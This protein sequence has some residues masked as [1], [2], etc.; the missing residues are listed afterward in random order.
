MIKE[1]KIKPIIK[2]AGGKTSEL[3]LIHQYLPK[4]FNNYYEPFIGG[5]AVWLSLESSNTNKMF[6][7]D[8]SIDLI[9]LYKNIQEQ[10]LE[11][12]NF[13][14]KFNDLWLHIN[15]FCKENSEYLI[16]TYLLFKNDKIN[17]LELK[18]R[19][20]EIV[21]SKSLS[22]YFKNDILLKSY[23]KYLLDKFVRT[24]N[25]EIKKGNLPFEDYIK[26][27]ETGFKAAL[28]MFIRTIY[29]SYLTKKESFSSGLSSAFYFIIRDLSYSGMF[30]Y[31]K[32]GEFNVPYGG[33][34]YNKKDFNNKINHIK[35][36]ELIQHFKNTTI[37]QDDF[38]DFMKKYKPLKNDFIFLD[39]PYDTNFSDYEG[40]E[41]NKNDQKRLADYL[42]NEC[43]GKWMVVIK[44]TDFIHSLYNKEGIEIIS[45]DKRYAVSFMDRN[46]QEV[47]HILIR[48]YGD[49]E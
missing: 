30:R 35:S 10:N 19:I 43:K 39:P 15:I 45:F 18:E 24:K 7:N 11:F 6:V 41:F 20:N 4:N 40:N 49:D 14:S 17:I 25:N 28:Y 16:N 1:K 44:Y 5:G 2:W 32:S 47:T 13:I 36:K 34:G 33:M 27:I 22:F 37:N 38:Y 9:N 12:L 48:N 42:I 46:D 29:N 3:P 31:N 8:F 21:N 26:N 23:N